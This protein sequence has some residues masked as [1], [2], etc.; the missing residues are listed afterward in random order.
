MTPEE[1]LAECPEFVLPLD[2]KERRMTW[3]E[4][5]YFPFQVA[6][7]DGEVIVWSRQ[8]GDKGKVLLEL[9]QSRKEARELR[10]GLESLQKGIC[11]PG[12]PG[13]HHYLVVELPDQIDIILNG[14]HEERQLDP[15]IVYSDEI[16][17]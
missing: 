9:A 11:N 15:N 7:E 8:F 5:R 12:D 17:F 2:Y 13:V 3:S 14:P 4:T 10:E 1:I 6:E 16:P